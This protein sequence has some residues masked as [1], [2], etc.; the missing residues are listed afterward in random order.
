MN[1]LDVIRRECDALPGPDEATVAAARAALLREIESWPV[2]EPRRPDRRRMRRSLAVAASLAILITAVLV[3]VIP[4]RQ[5]PIGVRI[6][7]AADEA[8]SPSNGDIVHATSRSVSVL[9]SLVT[10]KTIT[11]TY[12]DEWWTTGEPPY[13]RVDRYTSADGYM[14]DTILTTPCGQISYARGANLF[15]VSPGAEATR[16]F[17][18]SPAAAYRDAYRH[19]HVHYR[20][21]TTFRGIPAFRLD[22]TQYGLVSTLIVRRDNGYPLK[23]VSRRPSRRSVSTY[24]TTFSTFEHIPRTSES[25]RVL[26]L[27]PQP[28]AFF[29]RMPGTSPTG[30]SCE[31]FGSLQSLTGRGKNP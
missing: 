20:G 28:G 22:V 27:P 1:E 13:A 8:L 5:S 3:L 7:A 15:S 6:A 29:V 25:E 12:S 16:T 19:G 9:R 30:E 10:G 26:Q 17:V 31:H 14:D 23:T 18:S 2:I 4:A 11:S 21:K 24:I